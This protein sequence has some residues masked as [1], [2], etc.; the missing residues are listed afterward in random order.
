DFANSA[1]PEFDVEPD[2]LFDL[3][4]DL[5]FCQS[6][7][8][9]SIA[10]RN[11]RSENMRRYFLFE[12]GE[13]L[14]RAGRRAHPNQSLSLPVLRRFLV[15]ASGLI[16]RTGHRSISSMRTKS[17]VNA[18]SRTFTTRVTNELNNRFR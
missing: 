6:H 11:I 4:V 2:L 12:A 8:C 16:K 15:I 18:V 5:L 14:T 13:K 7:T 3:P 1:T 17:Q 10:N 9:Q